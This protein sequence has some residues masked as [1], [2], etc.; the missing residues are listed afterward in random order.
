[1]LL[2]ATIG[3]PFVTIL[4]STHICQLAKASL[5]HFLFICLDWV[6]I[7][8]F[9]SYMFF[10]E[11]FYELCLLIV[12]VIHVDGDKYH[13]LPLGTHFTSMAHRTQELLIYSL[14]LYL[15]IYSFLR[16][17]KNLI[18]LG[19]AVRSARGRGC[20]SHDIQAISNEKRWCAANME[21]P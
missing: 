15:C 7:S 18:V 12:G 17:K 16:K 4:L 5:V 6:N 13:I 20:P 1:M 9:K 2:N 14:V 19:Y 8:V 21:A 3:A 11:A 10:I